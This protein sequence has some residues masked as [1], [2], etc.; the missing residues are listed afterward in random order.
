M[1]KIV[2][3]KSARQSKGLSK[4]GKQLKIAK[5]VANNLAEVISP[6][7][8]QEQLIFKGVSPKARTKEIRRTQESKVVDS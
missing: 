8:E 4:L 7:E 1:E 6:I 3:A 5:A 2:D